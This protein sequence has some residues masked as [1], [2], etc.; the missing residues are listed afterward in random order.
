MFRTLF[1]T[2]LLLAAL[3]TQAYAQNCGVADPDWQ[4]CAADS[5]CVVA[6]NV[7][8]F[9]A[10]YNGKHVEAIQARNKCM[11]PMVSCARPLENPKPSE[12]YCKEGS[13][14]LKEI[15]P[16]GACGRFDLGWLACSEDADCALVKNAC[17]RET[18]YN[19][20]HADKAAAYNQCVSKQVDCTG[21][22]EETR[23]IKAA[24]VKNICALAE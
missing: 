9:P 8:G 12:A 1:A 19:K 3:T 22:Q 5:D 10:S 14:A 13:C 18:A 23:G 6:K 16:A 2:L 17:G 24:C 11:G 4:L 15:L 7:C 21:P 20:D